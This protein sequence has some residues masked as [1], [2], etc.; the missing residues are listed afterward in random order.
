MLNIVIGFMLT[1]RD[2][3]HL[4]I[5]IRSRH[6]LKGYTLMLFG[7]DQHAFGLW[8]TVEAGFTR[9]FNVNKTRLYLIS[10]HQ[11][12]RQERANSQPMLSGKRHYEKAT[13]AFGDFF[14]FFLNSFL[15]FVSVFKRKFSSHVCGSL[16]FAYLLEFLGDLISKIRRS[17]KSGRG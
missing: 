11:I 1:S 15:D 6:K 17:V 14:I 4:R 5:V 3:D 2:D 9:Q 7:T 13:R 12:F 16:A 8:R 10:L